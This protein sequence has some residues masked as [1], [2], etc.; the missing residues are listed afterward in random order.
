MGITSVSI[1]KMLI[2]LSVM[3]FCEEEYREEGL[4]PFILI[5][6]KKKFMSQPSFLGWYLNSVKNSSKEVAFSGTKL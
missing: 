3:D 4:E 2:E 5:N 6:S 1:G